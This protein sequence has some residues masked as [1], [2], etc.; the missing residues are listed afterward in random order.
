M[1]NERLAWMNEQK[2]KKTES[3]PDSEL[4]SEVE[5]KIIRWNEKQLKIMFI[6]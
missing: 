5:S 4:V 3:E 6:L 2:K 1:A